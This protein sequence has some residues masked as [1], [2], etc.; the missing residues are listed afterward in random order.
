MRVFFCALSILC[1][2]TTKVLA[3]E[4][5]PSTHGV[6]VI[7]RGDVNHW[8]SGHTVTG[9]DDQSRYEEDIYAASFT[10]EI[11]GLAAGTYTVEIYISESWANAADMRVFDISSD[12]TVIADDLDL[13][14]VAGKSVEHLI[15]TTVEVT[16]EPIELE[17]EASKDNAMLNAIVVKD[18][19]ENVV[20]SMKAKDLTTYNPDG[21][22]PIAV[23]S[24]NPIIKHD[25]SADPSAHVWEDGKIWIYAS[26]DQ[27]DATGYGSMDGYRCYS[28]SNMVDW[29]DHGEILHSRDLISSNAQDGWMFAPDAAYKNGTYYLYYPHLTTNAGWKIGVATSDVPQGP[30]ADQGFI[31]ET[32]HI[33]PTCFI[34]DDGAAY[35][36]WGGGYGAP[37]IAKLK[38]NMLELAEEPRSISFGSDN[39]GEGAYMHKRDGIYYFSYTDNEF[40][41]G[42]PDQSYYAMGDSPYGPFEYKGALKEAPEG[43]QD[44]HSIVEYKGNWYYFYHVGNHDGGDLYRRNVCVDNLYY[45]EDGSI[46]PVVGTPHGVSIIEPMRDIAPQ[47]F[48]N[49]MGIGINLGNTLDTKSANKTAWGNP[50]TTEEI[51][52]GILSRGFKTLRLPVTWQYNMGEGPDFEIEA[53]YLHRVEEIAKWALDNGAYVILNTHHDGHWIVPTYAEID[54][55][56]VQLEKV[57]TQIANHFK[58]YGDHLIFETLN[59]PR[60]EGGGGQWGEWSGGIAET[61]DCVNQANKASLDAIRATGGNNAVRMIMVPTHAA[62]AAGAAMRDWEAPND[63]PNVIVSIHAYSPYQFSLTD[64]DPD[65]GTDNDKRDLDNLFD[66]IYDTMVVGKG[67]AVVMGEWGEQNNGLGN[68]LDR[69]RHAEFYSKGCIEHG[70]CPVYWDDGGKFK[71]Y[72]RGQLDW[73]V[74]AHADAILGPLFGQTF[75]LYDLFDPLQLGAVGDDD[76][77]G[78]SNLLEFAFGSDPRDGDD[79]A[80]MPAIEI[81]DGI[82]TLVSRRRVS[83]REYSIEWCEELIANS[84]SAFTSSSVT[85]TTVPGLEGVE[86]VRQEVELDESSS[87]IFLRTRVED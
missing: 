31:Q 55:T 65:W 50:E 64:Q 7:I 18:A 69:T 17:F 41:G 23:T 25:R 73:H 33:D 24:G 71:V 85:T 79:V 72:E 70:I 44:H 51:I 68:Q 52:D 32:D 56:N 53:A 11:D 29:T 80:P 86:E 12:N 34:D 19:G 75:A 54:A 14:A 20:A 40:R 27:D 60:V 15:S 48:V 66:S 87:R 3:D 28:S 77:D 21:L 38:D 1:G 78:V 37:K 13:F 45:N 6:A 2:F 30:F 4:I 9:T 58:N 76:G 35:L 57:W 74:Q 16:T 82:L 49:D 36:I 81:A 39:F 63:D 61:R 84:W 26:H 62:S 8:R 67:R 22:T 43:A 59:E 47:Q 10:A 5:G 83:N 46:Q 42:W